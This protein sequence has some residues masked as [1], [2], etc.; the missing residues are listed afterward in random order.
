VHKHRSLLSQNFLHN[1]ELVKKLIRDS[2]IGKNDLVLEIGAG[3]GIILDQ[4]L[5]V[6]SQVIAIEID[7]GLYKT[8]E[9]KYSDRNNLNLYLGDALNFPTPRTKYKVFSNIPFALEGELVRKFLDDSNPPEDIYLIVRGDFAE[10]LCKKNTLINI[11]NSPFFE[12]KIIYHFKPY[13]FIP[14]TKVKP[15]MLRIKRRNEPLINFSEKQKYINFIHQGFGEGQPIYT[16]L[17]HKFRDKNLALILKNCR[18]N[19]DIKP[20]WINLVTWIELYKSLR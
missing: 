1:R 7:F 6:S 8:L 10:R 20:G 11:S 14:K 12:F 5:D 19:K 2:S 9:Q 13:D 4:L 17:K 15:V 3:D 16:N 18:L